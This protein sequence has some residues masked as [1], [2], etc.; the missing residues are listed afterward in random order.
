MTLEGVEAL[1]EEEELGPFIALPPDTPSDRAPPAAELDAV[2]LE[3][4]VMDRGEGDVADEGEGEGTRESDEV[5]EEDAEEEETETEEE[6]APR[7]Q[8][9]RDPAKSARY[10]LNPADYVASLGASVSFDEPE[11]VESGLGGMR[12]SWIR[13]RIPVLDE[14]GNAAMWLN[15]DSSDRMGGNMTAELRLHD[16]T[17][18]FDFARRRRASAVDAGDDHLSVRVFG[19]AD[20]GGRIEVRDDLVRF[21]R[22]DGAGGLQRETTCWQAR[23]KQLACAA[24]LC[25]PTV[26][27]GAAACY[28]Q[29]MGSPTYFPV[30]ALDGSELADIAQRGGAFNCILDADAA[31]NLSVLILTAFMTADRMT[32]PPDEGGVVAR[33]CARAVAQ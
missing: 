13:G 12:S 3:V 19:R 32:S 28:R 27:I 9:F 14:H 4:M 18:F 33:W 25:L 8:T 16:G 10:Y 2:Q 26:G 15:V 7:A 24:C 31:T 20:R 1:E 11:N 17:C 5:E 29:A 6:E 23:T 21:V 22:A 30:Q